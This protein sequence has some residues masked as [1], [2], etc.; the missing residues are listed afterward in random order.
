MPLKRPPHTIDTTSEDTPG[1]KK[2]RA[3]QAQRAHFVT[4]HMEQLTQPRVMEML[5][6]CDDRGCAKPQIYMYPVVIC[7]K[8]EPEKNA[9]MKAAYVKVADASWNFG[10]QVFANDT[11][12]SEPGETLRDERPLFSTRMAQLLNE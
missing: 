12:P 9:I 2:P 3:S 6:C 4:C 1:T 7:S 10:C 5:K 11:V 8:C